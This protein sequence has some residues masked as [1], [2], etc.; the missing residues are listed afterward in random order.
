PCGGGKN[1]QQSAIE[2]AQRLAA[3]WEAS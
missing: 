3:E 1:T 2:T